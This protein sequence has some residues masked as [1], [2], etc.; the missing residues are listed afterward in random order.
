MSEDKSIYFVASVSEMDELISYLEEKS[1]D[2]FSWSEWNK[3]LIKAKIIR[4]GISKGQ[5]Q[6][7]I[8]QCEH[9]RKLFEY[10][11]PCGRMNGGG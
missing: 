4:L 10:C 6:V 5:H 2:K 1:N 8:P 3:A 11:E 9:G 7:P